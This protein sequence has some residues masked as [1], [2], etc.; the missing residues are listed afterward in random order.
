MLM[1]HQRNMQGF[2][3]YQHCLS[4][5]YSDQRKTKHYVIKLCFAVTIKTIYI[6]IHRKVDLICA[7]HYVCP[8][9][10]VEQT[11][12]IIKPEAVDK[13]VEIE[14]IIMKS[15]FTI[16]NVNILIMYTSQYIA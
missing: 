14:E 9:I 6:M 11:L 13:V 12:A 10:Y 5:Y 2:T 7:P 15:G 4:C 3:L 1:L 8:Q 16:L